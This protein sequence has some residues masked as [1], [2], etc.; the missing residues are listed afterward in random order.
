ML[1]YHE[2]PM[3]RQIQRS[4]RIHAV[5]CL[6]AFAFAS[7]QV[8]AAESSAEASA[9]TESEKRLRDDIKKLASDDWEGRGLGTQGIN[10]AAD[11]IAAEFKRLGYNTELFDGTPFQKFKVTVSNK[12]G[13][14]ERNTL[15]FTPTDKESAAGQPLNK[16]PLVFGKGFTPLSI[17]GSGKVDLPI[18][19]VGYGISSK[20][21]KYDDYEGVD[22]KGKAVIMLRHEPQ[23]KNPHSPFEGTS[24]SMHAPLMRKV[25]NAYQ[26][27]AAAVMFVT[28]EVEI[29]D[30]VAA[31][32]KR[33]EEALEK[34]KTDFEALAKVKSDDLEALDEERVRLLRVIENLKTQGTDLGK[35]F[36][37][38]LPF[39]RG[40]SDARRLPVVHVRRLLIDQLFKASGQPTLAKLEADID[41]DL[42]PRSFEV[43]GYRLQGEVHVERVEA[44]IKNVVGV[45]EGS[46][47]LADET[48]VIGAHYDHLGR[49]EAGSLQVGSKEIHNGADDNASGTA[50]LLD[51]ARRLAGK[52]LPRRI[53][54]IAFTGEERG[55]LGS[56]HY[57]HNALFPLSKTVTM[58][59]MDMV[60]RLKND[61]LTVYGTGTAKGFEELVTKINDREPFHFKIKREPGGLGP[62]DHQTFYLAKIPVFHFFT[63]LHNDYHRPSDDVDKLNIE[64]MR[65]IGEFV[66]EF[67]LAI[68]NEP[69]PPEFQ[70]AKGEKFGRG[71]TEKKGAR[72]YFGSIPD[73][74]SNA[75]GYTLQGVAENGPAARGGL[76]AN[77]IIIGVAENKIGNLD[78]FDSAL[79]KFK[80]GDTVEITVKR[81][82]KELKLKV[83][84]DPPK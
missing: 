2:A 16:L 7:S 48:I 64:G 55:L 27:G 39:E 57:I 76:Q 8:S 32:R 77:D 14:A 18:V 54:L 4:P 69:Q 22:V 58:L 26:H 84:L 21:D 19:F 10:Q 47:P 1:S 78:D 80:G 60:G 40:D 36:D 44:E 38:L 13:K 59:N 75:E 6:F 41:S 74:G 20:D 61:D 79:R 52:K 43:P 23:Q 68:A 50:V 65:R 30:K 3:L 25:S 70:T 71:G 24:D 81:D 15:A 45:M 5:V 17:G 35:E 34:A 83:T 9:R 11:F 31:Q 56:G 46:G 49:G 37:P 42:K 28:D 12:L 72:P 67:A 82:G 53:V 73:L 63:G 33:W 51:V 62:S 66:T 29:R